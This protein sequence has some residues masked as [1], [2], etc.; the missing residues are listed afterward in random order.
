MKHNSSFS[1]KSQPRS[2]YSAVAPAFTLIE[3]LVVITLI[4]VLLTVGAMGLKNMA[5]SSGVSSGV[6]IA[7]A[8]FSEARNLAKGTARPTRVLIHGQQDSQDEYHRKRFLRYMAIAQE[9]LDEDG[10]VIDGQWEVSSKGV[11][12]PKGVFFSQ[13]LSERAG[14]ALP[15][16]MTIELPGRSSTACFYYEFN[17]EGLINNPLPENDRVPAFVIVSGSLPPGK[18]EPI[19]RGKNI[20]GFVIWRTGRTS[21]FRH[22][23]QIDPSF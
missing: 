14:V 15:S 16:K 8:V 12:L 13:M 23:D 9:A 20:G 2:G 11:N 17:A 3:L 10:N 5:Q 4:T 21:I 6:P 7:E 1:Q 18:D 19:I 22:P